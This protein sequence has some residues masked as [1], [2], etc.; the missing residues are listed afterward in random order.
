MGERLGFWERP[1]RNKDAL[2]QIV[3]MRKEAQNQ[4]RTARQMTNSATYKGKARWKRQGQLKG[5]GV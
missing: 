2:F 5:Q 3:S 1:L 4:K